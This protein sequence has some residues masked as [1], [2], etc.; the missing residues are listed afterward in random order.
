MFRGADLCRRIIRMF[1]LTEILVK[2]RRNFVEISQN[3][4]EILE[5]LQTFCKN[6]KIRWQNV[7]E[8]YQR[9]G[10]GVQDLEVLDALGE[11]RCAALEVRGLLVALLRLPELLPR[12][13]WR[14]FRSSTPSKSPIAH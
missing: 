11:V 2:F 5:F 6:M 1:G 12:L 13:L 14:P 4:N 10:I 3:L 7:A 9:F 8:F